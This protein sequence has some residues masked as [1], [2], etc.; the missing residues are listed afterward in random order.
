MSL[1]FFNISTSMISSALGYNSGNVGALCVAPQVNKWSFYKPISLSKL[2]GLVDSDYYN[3][4][5]G[6]S[7]PTYSNPLD[8]INSLI[9]GATWTYNKPQGGAGSPFRLGDF[10]GYDHAATNWFDLVINGGS[11]VEY[12]NNRTFN[13]NVDIQYLTNFNKFSFAKT[14]VGVLDVGLILV[15][16]W[17]SRNNGYLYKISDIRDYEQL[18]LTVLTDLGLGYWYVVPV[19]FTHSGQAN[20]SLLYFNQN[21]TFYGTFYLLPAN[22]E[23]ITIIGSGGGIVLGAISLNFYSK[24]II[25][26]GY[27]VFMSSLKIEFINTNSFDVTLYLTSRMTDAVTYGGL[28]STNITIPANSSTV[29][30]LVENGKTYESVDGSPTL[31]LTYSYGSSSLTTSFDLNNY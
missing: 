11:S 19:L 23:I 8:L 28:D 27:T 29:V 24:N 30:E 10:R 14:G 9:S 22:P 3:N 15:N 6:F 5:D 31:E 16:S 12:G 7:I 18:N 13:L 2:S 26:A 1:P 21:S 17:T 25:I 4:D 20:N